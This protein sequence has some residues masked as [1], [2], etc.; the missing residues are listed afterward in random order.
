MCHL[1]LPSDRLRSPGGVHAQPAQGT[2]VH[3]H[4]AAPHVSVGRMA[5]TSVV[6]WTLSPRA[7][8]SQGQRPAQAPLGVCPLQLYHLPPGHVWGA[9][10]PRMGVKPWAVLYP[11]MSRR[12]YGHPR[13][14]G[15]ALS[16]GQIPPPA[17]GQLTCGSYL[18]S[19]VLKQE[20]SN[21]L[22]P[23][24]LARAR[25]TSTAQRELDASGKKM[26]A[27]G[28]LGCAHLAGDAPCPMG[29]GTEADGGPRR[30]GPHSVAHP[31]PPWCHP[32]AMT[33]QCPA[34]AAVLRPDP[35]C[36]T[37]SHQYSQLD[38]EHPHSARVRGSSSDP[39]V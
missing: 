8:A 3:K 21:M 17:L 26:R 18:F 7:G 31:A 33:P 29:G 4:R 32:S 36:P 5:L 14:A 30:R 16:G 27:L 13:R 1:W 10:A 2:P 20:T 12:D 22:K 25:G 37:T 23:W 11:A 6:P 39:L 38:I 19:L 15:A 9:L 24:T 35:A 28:V 34:L